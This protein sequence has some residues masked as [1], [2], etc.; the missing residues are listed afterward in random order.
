MR[1]ADR[2]FGLH[3]R[4][5]CCQVAAQRGVGMLDRDWRF[6]P[7]YDGLDIPKVRSMKLFA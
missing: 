5:G 3:D 6:Q 7:P 2:A 4:G 1:V